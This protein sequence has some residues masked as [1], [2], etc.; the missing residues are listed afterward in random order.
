MC[1]TEARVRP[2]LLPLL[3]RYIF[4]GSGGG[5]ESVSNGG[6]DVQLFSPHFMASFY[7][8]TNL[9]V[10]HLII[11]RML[12][13]LPP[14]TTPNQLVNK[15][16][17]PSPR[18]VL[19][20]YWP[21]PGLRSCFIGRARF[22]KYRARFSQNQLICQCRADICSGTAFFADL[23]SNLQIFLLRWKKGIQRLPERKGD[24]LSP[25]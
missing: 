25:R 21:G 3:Q 12:G 18:A 23:G 4:D 7:C 1:W 17:K 11:L 9:A 24:L 14:R 20:V 22:F 13:S 15:A 2:L 10:S 5:V 19:I 6:P 8:H 16:L